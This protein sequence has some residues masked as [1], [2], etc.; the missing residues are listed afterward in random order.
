MSEEKSREAMAR[1]YAGLTIGEQTAQRVYELQHIRNRDAWRLT[2]GEQTAQRV[3]DAARARHE[4]FR[5]KHPDVPAWEDLTT[6]ER[7]VAIGL[8]VLCEVPC[9]REK[10]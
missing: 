10:L 2:I 6:E 7:A 8:T 9:E 3:Y 4:R 5:P 1:A